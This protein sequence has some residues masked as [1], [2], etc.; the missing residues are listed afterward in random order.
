LEVLT[1]VTNASC[2]Q[3]FLPAVALFVLLVPSKEGCMKSILL[4]MAVLLAGCGAQRITC[5]NDTTGVINYIGG[6]DHETSANYVVNVADG[7]RDFYQK[8]NCQLMTDV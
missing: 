2:R 4:G 1:F 5:W 6:F 8:K 3:A 7:V